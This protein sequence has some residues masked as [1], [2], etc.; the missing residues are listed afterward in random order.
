M[1]RFAAILCLL[2]LA[3]SAPAWADTPTPIV[4]GVL[5]RINHNRF[6]PLT[7]ETV[8]ILGLTSQHKKVNIRVYTQR[9]T[10]IREI[11]KDQEPGP[12]VPAWDGRN[13]GNEVAGS[14]VYVIIVTGFKLEKRFR[15]AVIK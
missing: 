15:V 3:C 11:L 10:L 8:E 4:P 7:G 13:A 1:R 14:G 9:G 2:I 5:V 6:N 12:A